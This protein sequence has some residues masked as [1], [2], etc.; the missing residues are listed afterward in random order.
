MEK[1]IGTLI[2]KKEE[3]ATWCRIWTKET[4]SNKRTALVI[5]DENEI[6]NK[7]KKEIVKYIDGGYEEAWL[8]SDN[9]E[10]FI[11][12]I[13]LNFTFEY[14][15]II[16]NEFD[17]KVGDIFNS[18]GGYTKDVN[19]Y[20]VV[21]RVNDVVYIRKIEY[22]IVNKDEKLP[23]KDR[24]IGTIFNCEL[25]HFRRRISIDLN[26]YTYAYKWDGNPKFFI[27]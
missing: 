2:N 13:Y 14:C 23:I 24:F 3:K 9:G 20:Q 26:T 6:E 12:K 7:N 16:K 4:E 21:K 22:E 5:G 8:Y 11:N 27:A 1:Y 25:K 18:E 17:V 15:E 19:F 10:K